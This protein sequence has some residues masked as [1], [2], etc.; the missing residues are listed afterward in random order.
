MQP[1][2]CS[3]S[4]LQSVPLSFAINQCIC[5][6]P[7]HPHQLV[8]SG[9][10]SSTVLKVTE[11]PGPSSV[12]A[13]ASEALSAYNVHA[14][15]R[16]NHVLLPPHTSGYSYL[17]ARSTTAPGKNSRAAGANGSPACPLMVVPH[18]LYA[19][20]VPVKAAAPAGCSS[21]GHGPCYSPSSSSSD[22]PDS[23]PTSCLAA[24]W[25][26]CARPG[27]RLTHGAPGMRAVVVQEM[28]MAHGKPL[29]HMLSVRSQS[30]HAIG[31]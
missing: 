21:G 16:D 12:R 6:F 31:L 28:P 2:S 29:W 30:V 4:S 27:W 26:A 22:S 14:L 8:C 11:L 7:S 3:H 17:S 1:P 10:D 18:A 20:A 15:L 23:H 25:S 5:P 24:A 13:A 9:P 19:T